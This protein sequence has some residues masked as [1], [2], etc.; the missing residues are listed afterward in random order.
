MQNRAMLG[1]LAALS[2]LAAACGGDDG[3]A[4]PTPDSIVGEYRL[5][6]I[7]GAALPFTFRPDSL[8]D[9]EGSGDT[10][11]FTE[12]VSR[13]NYTLSANGRFTNSYRFV[14]TESTTEDGVPD[15]TETLDEM[16]LGTWSRTTLEGQPVVRLVAD[17]IV[18]ASGRHR[19]DFP[20]TFFIPL[21]TATGWTF[22]GQIAHASLG[23]DEVLV[24]YTIVYVK[25]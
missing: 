5:A 12:T 13:D 14:G 3:P 15:V 20:F 11:V 21:P 25:Q 24:P 19:L 18:D 9:F 6:T 2:I 22:S 23:P 8:L 10:L 16:A 17:S 4:A 1:A 7:N